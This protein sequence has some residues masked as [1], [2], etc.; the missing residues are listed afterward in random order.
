MRCDRFRVFRKRFSPDRP[1]GTKDRS[2]DKLQFMHI[3]MWYTY[4]N[5]NVMYLP[6]PIVDNIMY[7]YLCTYIERNRA[8]PQNC[9]FDL[10]RCIV[11]LLLCDVVIR[12]RVEFVCN[13]IFFSPQTPLS[14]GHT[15]H[16]KR[17]TWLNDARNPRL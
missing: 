8:K 16:Q 13:F 4:Y 9:S 5:D 11:L 1:T 2:D 15:L 14:A 6:I 17:V 3:V 10:V 12:Q 7:V